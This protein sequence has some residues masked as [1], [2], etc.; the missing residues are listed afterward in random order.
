[1]EKIS[2]KSKEIKDV[3]PNKFITKQMQKLR[4]REKEFG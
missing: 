2:R 1:M 3:S 4:K